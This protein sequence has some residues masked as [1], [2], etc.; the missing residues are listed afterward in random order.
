[1]WRTHFTWNEKNKG[2]KNSKYKK[3]S[4][5]GEN[6]QEKEQDDVA[7]TSEE[8]N[9]DYLSS[10][11][12]RKA[13]H[14]MMVIRYFSVYFSLILFGF[15]SYFFFQG[16]RNQYKHTLCIDFCTCQIEHCHRF[17]P[18]FFQWSFAVT[19]LLICFSSRCY[20]FTL[21]LLVRENVIWYKEYCSTTIQ[22][23]LTSMVYMCIVVAVGNFRHRFLSP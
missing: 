3:T 1:M 21:R 2:K 19:F 7:K 12:N 15:F 16:T 13:K 6:Q 23:H 17:Y 22:W 8:K 11:A 5:S 4:T 20:S 18:R 10:N 9:K 14:L